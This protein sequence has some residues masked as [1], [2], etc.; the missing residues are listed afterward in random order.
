MQT[1]NVVTY[2]NSKIKNKCRYYKL[3][4]LMCSDKGNSP[5]HISGRTVEINFYKDV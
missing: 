2:I 5:K 1:K 4:V 3:Q